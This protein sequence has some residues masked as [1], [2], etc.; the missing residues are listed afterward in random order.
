M[1][2]PGNAF[3]EVGRYLTGL[4]FRLIEDVYDAQAFGSRYV[5]YSRGT[6]DVRLIWDGKEEW[7]LLELG[8]AATDDWTELRRER[9][10]RNTATPENLATLT[11]AL[12]Q[13]K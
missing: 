6:Q 5:V 9:V 12:Q 4:K 7:L 13:V 10:G 1:G 11:T 3:E 8:N 2:S